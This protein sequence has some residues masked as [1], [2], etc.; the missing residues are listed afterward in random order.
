[1]KQTYFPAIVGH[2]KTGANRRPRNTGALMSR[3]AH[4]AEPVRPTGTPRPWPVLTVRLSDGAEEGESGA[5]PLAALD[6]LDIRTLPCDGI[7]AA[8][9]ALGADSDPARPVAAL[10]YYGTMVS[11]AAWRA[12]QRLAARAPRLRLIALMEGGLAGSPA[13][14]AMIRQGMIYDVHTL[15]IDRVR[16]MATLGHVAGLVAL[17]TQTPAADDPRR[18]GSDGRGT[19]LDLTTARQQLEERLMREAL[20]KNPSNIKR[21]A[22]E[23]GVSRVTFYRMM[24]RYALR[25]SAPDADEIKN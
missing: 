11:E 17:E 15:P 16:L 5:G 24:D 22:K 6:E 14:G 9:A 8:I 19:L 10:L 21:A 1:M 20:R 25:R 4:A 13:L 7:E 18:A 3:I 12:T 2:K 23:L